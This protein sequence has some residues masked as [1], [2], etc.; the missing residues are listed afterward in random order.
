MT[1]INSFTACGISLL[2]KLKVTNLQKYETASSS[3]VYCNMGSCIIWFMYN[4]FFLLLKPK[5]TNLQKSN[6]KS[7]STVSGNMFFVLFFFFWKWKWPI[8]EILTPFCS[9]SQDVY[10]LCFWKWKCMTNLQKYKT[11][12]S[13][14]LKH[15]E[16]K[17]LVCQAFPPHRISIIFEY[18]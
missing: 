18:D 16:T 17:F 12:S 10:F 6:A 7:P 4:M 8:T 2:L 14:K 11:T 3:T 15:N 1:D 9:F 13:S 5:V